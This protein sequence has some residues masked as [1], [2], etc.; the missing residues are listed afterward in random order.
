[1][2]ADGQKLL[3]LS[4]SLLVAAAFCRYLVNAA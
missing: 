4:L 1:M 2:A 3:V